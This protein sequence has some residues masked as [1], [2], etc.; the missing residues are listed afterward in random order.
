[1]PSGQALQEDGFDLL[2][3]ARRERRGLRP[4]PSP[5]TSF[6]LCP[7]AVADRHRHWQ[8]RFRRPRRPREQPSRGLWIRSNRARISRTS[9]TRAGHRRDPV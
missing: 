5:G 9:V 8:S 1:M 6:G 4:R 2:A 7:C 3:G